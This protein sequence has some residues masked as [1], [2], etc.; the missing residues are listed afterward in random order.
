MRLRA[1]DIQ[2]VKQ[3]KVLSKVFYTYFII[4]DLVNLC[5]IEF[6][7]ID[8]DFNVLKSACIGVGTRHESVV[9]PIMISDQLTTTMA[10]RN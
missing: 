8:M 7:L 3:H 4:Q 6:D 1:A 2:S 5:K 9:H 10:E